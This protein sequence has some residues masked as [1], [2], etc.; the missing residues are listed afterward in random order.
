MNP[1]PTSKPRF[2][3]SSAEPIELVEQSASHHAA[4]RKP[5]NVI[6]PAVS[7]FLHAV[8]LVVAALLVINP[9]VRGDG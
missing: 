9:P 3:G 7:L 6:G 5:E 2:S 8:F 4:F 1:E